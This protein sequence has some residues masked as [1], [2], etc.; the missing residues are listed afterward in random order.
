MT[1]KSRSRVT[2][3]H[4]KR[5]HWINHTRLT[6]SRVI[7]R[8]CYRDLEMWVRGHSRSLKMVPVESLGMV[9]YSPS[10]VPMAIYWAISQI[11]SIREWSD[12]E[13]WVW[14]RSRWFKMARFDRPCTTFYWPA[15][16]TVAPYCT[17]FELFYVESSQVVK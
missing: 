7:W 17:T 2:Q 8:W 13:I 16:V 6:I 3:V 1:L 14:G 9:S 5:N 12:L 4:W 11:L 10:M 15:I